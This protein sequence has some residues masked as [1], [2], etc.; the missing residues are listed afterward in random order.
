[1][2]LEEELNGRKTWIK[3]EPEE[4]F[5]VLNS[6]EKKWKNKNY[7]FFKGKCNSCVKY[8]NRLSHFL[9]N[10]NKMTTKVTIRLQEIPASAVN[11]TTVERGATGLLVVGEIKEK[12][13]TMT[14]I[15]YSW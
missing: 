7:K 9:V 6:G 11:A 3:Y 15:T 13:E 10:I 8:G 14:W 1:M 2:V 4:K 12:G 5:L